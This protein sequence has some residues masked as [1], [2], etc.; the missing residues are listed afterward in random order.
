MKKRKGNYLNNKEEIP[1]RIVIVGR[2]R[3]RSRSKN[4]GIGIT[5]GNTEETINTMNT[6]MRERRRRSIKNTKTGQDLVQEIN[7][8]A[9]K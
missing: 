8:T 5:T 2:K 7:I 3:R 9:D 1:D 6:E 4:K